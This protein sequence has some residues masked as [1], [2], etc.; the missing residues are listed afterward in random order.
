MLMM[1]AWLFVTPVGVGKRANIRGEN[2]SQIELD[3][4]EFEE[5]ICSQCHITRPHCHCKCPYCGNPECVCEF[6][7]E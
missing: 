6:S 4:A 3:S 7:R 1:M 5:Q 2:M